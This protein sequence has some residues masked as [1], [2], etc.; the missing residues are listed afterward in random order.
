[1]WKYFR[2]FL[3]VERVEK[4]DGAA[5]TFLA[6]RNSA[7][8]DHFK[9]GRKAQSLIYKHVGIK[10]ILKQIYGSTGSLSRLPVHAVAGL[11]C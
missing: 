11:L 8:L 9:M 1:M 3:S 6:K 7:F 10:S 4:S 2:A 5:E